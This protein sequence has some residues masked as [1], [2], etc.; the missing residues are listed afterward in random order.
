MR[1]LTG[2]AGSGKTAFFLDQLRSA[3]R[4]GRRDVRLVVPTSTMAQHLQNL[5]AREGFVFPRRLIQTLSGF[6]EGYVIVFPQVPDS[7][8]YLLV[9]EAVARAGRPEF[10][11]VAGLP[12]FCASLAR[13]IA[14]FSSAGCDSARLA[15][16]L[17]DAPLA[18]A[19]LAVYH[20][21]ERLLDRRGMML[22][23]RRLEC[24]AAHIDREGVS[25]I[26]EIWFDGFHALPEP[27]LGLVAALARK[28]RVTLALNDADIDEGLK[29]RLNGIGF[30]EERLSRKRPSAALA[31]VRAPSI[32]REV[33]EIARRILQQAAAG[34]AFR[35]MAI[36]VR[37]AELYI[38][39]LRTTLER[40]GIPARFYFDEDAEQQPPIR[41]LSAAVDAMLDGWEHGAVLRFLRLAPR[42]LRSPILDQ[43]DFQVR[44]QIPNSG[45]ASIKAL[46]GERETALFHIVDGLGALEEWRSFEMV[47]ADWAARF[48]TLRNLYRPARPV[49]PLGA[50]AASDGAALDLFDEALSEAVRALDAGRLMGIADFWQTVKSVLRLKPLRVEDGRRNVLHILSAHEARQW[51]L[52]V[53]FVCGMVEK[54]FP[55]FRPQDPFFPDSARARLHGAGIGVRTAAEFDREERG[56]FDSALAGA[57]SLV[58]FSY[59]E[60]DSRGDRNLSSLFLEGM[61][62][63][64]EEALLVRPMPR[65]A[66][67]SSGPP[68]IRTA[69]LLP[70]LAEKTSRISPSALDT[71]SQCAFQFFCKTT[72]RLKVPPKRPQERLDFSMQGEIVH[73][74]LA[75]WYSHPQEMEPLFAKVFDTYCDA[76]RIPGGYHTERLRNAMLT[77]LERFAADD[78]W[79]RLAFASQMEQKFL[80][81]LAEDLDLSG[82]IDRIDTAADG[83]CYVV[84]YKYSRAQLV[85]ER[86][87]DVP[88]QAPL[89]V[90]AAE[91]AFGVKASG[92]FFVG[93]KAGVQYAGWSDDGLI[94]AD[95]L[96]RDWT[97]E[98]REKVSGMVREIRAGR[99]VPNPTDR[100]RCVFCDARD[101]C[102][103]ETG[104]VEPIAEGA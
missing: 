10:R 89:Y 21:V 11:R 78:R 7:V 71:Y 42:F 45:L 20:E 51:V 97:E 67:S 102:R 13:T 61:P 28:T 44:E 80:F 14:E 17:P 90:I 43:L 87:K 19:F 83:R 66:P 62:L 23:A 52:P 47:P 50:S 4:E 49:E 75:E 5:I 36:I 85:K 18:S 64:D 31:L 84:D 48:G 82:R 24:A 73:A 68:A 29:A 15:T 55:R 12:G 79:P 88:L 86:K 40:F 46:L 70:V 100:D 101:I 58:T 34:R 91:Q 54:Q 2:P 94:D 26:S 32:E 37:T 33:E 96:P 69:S 98:A 59:P 56:L 104:T 57:T 16:S 63:V 53:F 27:E 103:F 74:V 77:D 1:L 95:P 35:E 92:F 9:E 6:V 39:L 30:E 3:L 22:R 25:G 99:V 8:V 93:L 60:F 72:L 41:F 81:P 65:F 76:R 38:P